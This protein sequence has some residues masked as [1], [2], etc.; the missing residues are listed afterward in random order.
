MAVAKSESE[1]QR[2]L[3]VLLGDAR[4][5][6]DLSEPAVARAIGVSQSRI[7]QLELGR[8]RLMLTEAFQLADLYGIGLEDLDPRGKTLPKGVAHGR[9]RVDRR[10]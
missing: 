4:Q 1:A 7:A 9:T 2:V 10:K 8:R 3:G 6:A 5:A